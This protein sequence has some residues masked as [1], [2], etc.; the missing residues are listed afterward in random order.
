[1]S[2]GPC[3]HGT[4]KWCEDC[5][6]ESWVFGQAVGTE[7]GVTVALEIAKKAAAD[8]FLSNDDK[9]AAG[10]RDL[11]KA[12]EAEKKRCTEDVEKVR[13]EHGYMDRL[14]EAGSKSKR[15]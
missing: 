12:L 11:V 6:S 13:K 9:K 1:M 10:L 7:T 15:S 5:V 14:K 3:R 4:E 2:K 8:A